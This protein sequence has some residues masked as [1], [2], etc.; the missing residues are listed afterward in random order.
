MVG[1]RYAYGYYKARGLCP[2]CSGARPSTPGRLACDVCGAQR[3]QYAR[4]NLERK[5]LDYREHVAN[6]VCPFCGKRD[7][8]PNR[9]ACAQCRVLE[10][11]YSRARH[12]RKR[13]AGTCVRNGC[14]VPAV[15]GRT[16]CPAHAAERNAYFRER[17]RR[18]VGQDASKTPVT[19]DVPALP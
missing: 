12:A 8:L 4:D 3:A 17:Y 19:A 9:V 1:K 15:T 2:Y 16:M 13:A 6:G 5:R 18:V 14:H 11:E 7:P 10:R